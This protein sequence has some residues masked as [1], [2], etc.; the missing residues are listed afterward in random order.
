MF[1]P[2]NRFDG[3]SWCGCSG[4]PHSSTW[5]SGCYGLSYRF[6]TTCEL[7]LVKTRWSSSQG[8]QYSRCELV[9][10]CD[11][12]CDSVMNVIYCIWK[13][14]LSFCHIFG[15]VSFLWSVSCWLPPPSLKCVFAGNSGTDYTSR[16]L[17]SIYKRDMSAQVRYRVYTTDVVL[18][19]FIYWD[20]FE[21]HESVLT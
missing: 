4:D 10:C 11:G 17:S 6:G 19:S 15:P 14:P 9:T 3:H 2:F 12:V 21:L 13:F 1:V 7:R 5:I 18:R 20:E 16:K 8:F